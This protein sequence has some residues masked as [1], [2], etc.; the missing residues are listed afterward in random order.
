MQTQVQHM[1]SNSAIPY[2]DLQRRTR[3]A[4]INRRNGSNSSAPPSTYKSDTAAAHEL[5]MKSIAMENAVVVVTT[6]GCCMSHVVTRLFCSL[7]V[8]PHVVEIEEL[9]VDQ[10]SNVPAVFIGGRLLGGVDRL[11]AAHITGNLVPQLKA[12]GALWL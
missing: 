3:D 9:E 7:G 1:G 6:K 5:G 12:A 4:T 10:G 2:T 8:N 11:L